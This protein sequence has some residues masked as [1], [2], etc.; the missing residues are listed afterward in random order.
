MYKQ[1][2][3]VWHRQHGI[4]V[5]RMIQAAES[6]ESKPMFATLYFDRLSLEMGVS[7]AAFD[8][9]VRPLMTES[10][11]GQLLGEITNLQ[12]LAEPVWR[13]RQRSNQE[14][15]SSGDPL[16]TCAVAKSLIRL[17]T[18]GALAASDKEQLKRSLQALADEL[19]FVLG[20]TQDQMVVRLEKA[21]VS[22]LNVA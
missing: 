3:T 6:A 19:S 17:R 14:R 12:E 7:Q 11:A 4:G 5:I 13:R 15:L 8:Q 18:R 20:G 22:S 1:G 2:D 16:E 10:E 21:C 9:R